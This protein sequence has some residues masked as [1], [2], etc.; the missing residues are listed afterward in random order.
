MKN[1]F[2]FHLL[3]LCFICILTVFSTK[4]ENYIKNK[5]PLRETPYTA[6]PIGS[7]RADGWLL[8]QLQLQ[9]DGLTGHA[10]SL[11]NH[12]NDLGAGCDWLGGSGDSWERAPYYTKGL[13]A[14]AYVMNDDELIAKA[15]KWIDWSLDNQR[16]NGY[17]GPTGNSDW[18][19][20]MPMLY[21]IRDYYEATNDER[22]IPF[23]TNY[24]KY[25]NSNIENQPLSSWGRS[26]AGDNIDIVFWLYNRTGDAFLLELADKLKNQAYDWTDILTNNRFNY[27]GTDFQPKHNVNVPQAMKLPVV[28]YQKSNA[29]A[30]RN[31]FFIGRE[32]LLCEHGQPQGMQSGNEMLAGRSSMTGLELCSVVEQMQTSEIAQM[33]L[34]DVIIG[35]QLEKVAFNALP[36]ALTEDIKGM[37]YYHMANQVMSKHANHY[38]GQNYD[39]GTIPGPYSG[40][41]CCRFDFHMGWPYFVKTMWAATA[42]DGLAAMA[43]GPCNV[44]AIVADNVEVSIKESTNY[45]FDEQLTF[46]LTA[47]K[48]VK[49][50]LKLRIP[51]WCENPQVKVNGVVQKNVEAG[52]F[53]TIDRK[54]S[55]NDVV[56]MEL[57][58]HIVLNDEVNNS[59]SVQ[60]GPLVYSL[61]IK[62]NKSVRNDYGNGFK[63]CEIF[64]ASDWNYALIV[65]KDNPENSIQVNKGEMPQNPY[66][67]TLTPVTLTV[68]AKKLPTW[69]HSHNSALATDPPYSPVVS[70]EAVEQV[71][72]V[73]F[74]AES[75]RAT[76]LPV[77]GTPELVT[78]YFQEGFSDGQKGWVQYAGSFYVENGEYVSTNIE[79][80][81]QWSKA[82]YPASRFSD[83]TYDAKVQLN[84]TGNHINGDAG[85]LFRAS[86]LSFGADEYSGYYVG[87]SNSN[88]RVELGK[89]N[90]TWTSLKT[91]PM[92]I[93]ADEWHHIRVVAKGTNIKVYVDDMNNPKIDYNDASFS[94][95]SIGIRTY[96]G[97]IARWDDIRVVADDY[98]GGVSQL[99]TSDKLTLRPNPAKNYIDV[100]FNENKYEKY[101]I[102]VFDL[103]GLLVTAKKSSNSASSVR[104]DTT[105]FIAGTYIINLITDDNES[106][107]G[108]FIKKL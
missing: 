73:P 51:S 98:V 100:I 70:S 27:F 12:A 97:L 64:P 87:I 28:Y 84:S 76:C 96:G 66:S 41:G 67:R 48:A 40:Y 20:R 43:Y 11:Y 9:K 68:S 39:N 107:N 52:K 103:N 54:W 85:I 36:G 34:G 99:K 38:F 21:A 50:P 35:D 45:P 74:G 15:Q 57:P 80:G 44:T 6:L 29:E 31:A 33:I 56:V 24:F 88:G 47:E 71:T 22:V 42:D 90:G 105:N 93:T 61:K 62:E 13:V 4:A 55:N 102:N 82:V 46:T 72:L 104:I 1:K 83:F 26:R 30:D 106:H 91:A 8:T 25:Q 78:G 10:E 58:M 101:H 7:V 53:Y 14:L 18:W 79:S 32:H 92:D 63:E 37:Q 5:A 89:A 49:F 17:F 69:E 59:V 19:A 94:S 16:R 75:I 60:R 95:G 3:A 81:H 2:L 77:V 108:K 23:F 65:D 86:R